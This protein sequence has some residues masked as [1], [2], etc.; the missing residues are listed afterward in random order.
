MAIEEDINK[1]IALYI[2]CV[3]NY[4]AFDIVRWIEEEKNNEHYKSKKNDKAFV[5]KA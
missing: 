3:V 2:D 5:N 1:F 4:R